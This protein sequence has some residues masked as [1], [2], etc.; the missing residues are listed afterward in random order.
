MEITTPSPNAAEQLMGSPAPPIGCTVDLGHGIYLR[1]RGLS[2]GRIL[3]ANEVVAIALGFPVGVASSLVASVIVDY[4]KA[5]NASG[6][7]TIRERDR[8]FILR[9][10]TFEMEHAIRERIDTLQQQ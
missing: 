5:R 4:F 10:G 1:Y 2:S 7:A 9:I 3:G 8:K 6:T